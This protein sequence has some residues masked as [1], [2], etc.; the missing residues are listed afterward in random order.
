MFGI[1]HKIRDP[2]TD[3]AGELI[4]SILDIEEWTAAK[5]RA[6]DKLK[7]LKTILGSDFTQFI[8]ESYERG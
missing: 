6:V 4:R 5:R 1:A 3:Q 7:S 8:E 2:L